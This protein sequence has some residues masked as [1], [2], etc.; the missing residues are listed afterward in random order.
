MGE[1][2][3]REGWG[4]PGRSIKCHYFRDGTS[5]CGKWGFYFGRLEP[6]TGKTGPDDC[7]ACAR[8]KE[9]ERADSY[10]ELPEKERSDE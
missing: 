5:L 3:R 8:A 10:K 1:I 9:K 2:R 6:D 4:F 7:K